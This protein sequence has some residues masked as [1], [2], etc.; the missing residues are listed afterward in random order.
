MLNSR[1]TA[2][3]PRG[4]Q[5]QQQIQQQPQQQQQQIQ[6]Q[7]YRYNPG[8][9][10]H[11]QPQTFP[12]PQH[13]QQNGVARGPN[14]HQYFQTGPHPNPAAGGHPQGYMYTPQAHAGPAQGL[15]P[16]Y[17]AGPQVSQHQGGA[18]NPSMY[19]NHPPPPHMPQQG[20][21][22][23]TP[24][25]TPPVV[26]PP[27]QQPQQQQPQQQPQ[28]GGQQQQPQMAG[29]PGQPGEISGLILINGKLLTILY[30]YFWND[31]FDVVIAVNWKKRNFLPSNHVADCFKR[32][33]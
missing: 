7:Q 9:P 22:R 14:P 18:P 33:L 8:V 5:P 12:F 23:P 24:T 29:M 15:Y 17:V 26:A 13:Q 21:S 10:F 2:F 27:G 19:L 1:A 31:H 20:G 6:P 30:S 11:P 28:Q 4:C 32:V 3:V 25:Q 16:P